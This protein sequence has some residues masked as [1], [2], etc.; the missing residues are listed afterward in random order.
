[1]ITAQDVIQ[2]VQAT[3]QL[4]TLVVLITYRRD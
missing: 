4:L 1:M 2:I 3:I